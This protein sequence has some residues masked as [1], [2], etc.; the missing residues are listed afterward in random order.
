MARGRGSPAAFARS[1]RALASASP[2]AGAYPDRTSPALKRTLLAAAGKELRGNGPSA[3]RLPRRSR[4]AMA[5]G[6]RTS[7]IVIG[8]PAATNLPRG[9]GYIPLSEHVD[10]TGPVTVLSFGTWS[11]SEATRRRERRVSAGFE[12]RY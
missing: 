5:L 7:P 9:R 3:D 8:N 6:V 10:C 11:T 2:C 1:L 12:S 4:S